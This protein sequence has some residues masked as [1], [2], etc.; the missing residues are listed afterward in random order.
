MQVGV[1]VEVRVRGHVVRRLDIR[2][3]RLVRHGRRRTILLTLWNRGN[4]SEVVPL[5]RVRIVLRRGRRVLATLLPPRRRILPHSI[6]VL[7][8]RYGG[9]VHGWAQAAVVLR[10]P[11]P[12]TAI[13]RRTYRIRM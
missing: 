11:R 4:V 3:L 6:A 13:L 9:G 8:L 1:V 2:G 5:R 12:G 10:R 7:A